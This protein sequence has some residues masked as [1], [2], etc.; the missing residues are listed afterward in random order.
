MNP[1]HERIEAAWKRFQE[2]DSFKS[3][4]RI[5]AK[6]GS[7]VMDSSDMMIFRLGF[8]YGFAHG[9]TSAS[10]AAERRTRNPRSELGT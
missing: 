3:L 7:S 10:L 8:D 4:N 5:F 6:E 9:E 1:I 2:S